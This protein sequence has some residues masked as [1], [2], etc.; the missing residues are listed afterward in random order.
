[1]GSAPPRWG[2][3]YKKCDWAG[4]VLS[5][6]APTVLYSASVSR[7][8]Y[9]EYL[10]DQDVQVIRLACGAWSFID[11][12][13]DADILRIA[14][15][16]WR[17]GRNNFRT[18]PVQHAYAIVKTDRLNQKWEGII[19]IDLKSPEREDIHDAVCSGKTE[20]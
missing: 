1:M 11:R 18:R 2:A 4:M 12:I 13:I 16:K 7:S 9:L 3:E 20:P 8:G 6:K 15:M 17:S 19:P 14:A 10:R 5:A